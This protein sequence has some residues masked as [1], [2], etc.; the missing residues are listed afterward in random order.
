MTNPADT[1]NLACDV[2]QTIQY[3]DGLGRPLQTVQ[4]KGNP[5]GLKDVIQPVAYDAYGRE[6]TKYLPYTTASGNAGSYRADALAGAQQAFYNAPPSGVVTIPTPYATTI[7]E[8]SP[9][10]RPTEQ[11]APGND[12]QPGSGHTVRM[13][14]AFNTASG[15]RAVRLY[16]ANA[17][18]ITGHEHERNLVSIGNYNAGELYLNI[19]K[20]ENWQPTD[21]LAGQMHEYKDKQGRV[22]LKRTFNFN[23]SNPLAPYLETLS[24]YYV[25]DDLGNL[26][27]VLPPGANP[28]GS[29][30]TQVTQDALC[31]QY[32]YDGGKR[33]IEKKLPGKGWEFMVYNKL[34]QVVMTQ[35][36]NQR[37]KAPQEW[38]FTKYDALSR[39]VITGTYNHPGSTDGANHRQLFQGIADNWTPVFGKPGKIGTLI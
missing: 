11:G 16:N 21:G 39:V 2:M 36:P 14:Q 18:T 1:S 4:V 30:P 27:F 31:Y 17:V 32:R 13:E 15:E 8:P 20:D 26:S 7:F 28:D 5:N 25:Y 33:L 29:V 35:D 34:D 10:N 24:T 23:K 38:T 6:A 22:L 19:V 37:S 9:L 3:F 12:W